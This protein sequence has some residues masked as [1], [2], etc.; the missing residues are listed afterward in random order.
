MQTVTT[1]QYHHYKAA[2]QGKVGIVLDFNWYEALTNSTDDEAA[3]QRARDF[4]VGWFVDPL[5]NGHY[6]QIMQDLVKERLPRFTPDETK[7]VNGSADYI[8][9]NQYTANYIKGQKLVPQK[10]TSY[11]ADWQ[12][13][14]A[15][16]RN[17]I[18]IGPKGEVWKSSS[19]HN[20]KRY[21]YC[22]MYLRMDQPGNLTRDEYLHDITRIRYYRSYLAE[23]KRA[24]DGGANVLGYFAW[25]LLDNFNSTELERHPKALAYWFRDMLKV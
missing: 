21:R 10:P 1:D 11:S 19:R 8:G 2:Q 15:S 12:V 13:T 25:S 16:D 5:I 14:Y 22:S 9:I 4:H 7:L 20:R 23:L 6:P 24:I 3:A 17:G 18:P